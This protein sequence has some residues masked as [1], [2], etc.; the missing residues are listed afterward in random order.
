MLKLCRLLGYIGA[1]VELSDLI[2]NSDQSLAVQA[3]SS[4]T[5]NFLNVAGIGFTAWQND[6]IKPQKPFSYHSTE[7]PMYDRN[8][9][10]LADKISTNCA[11][12]HIRATGYMPGTSNIITIPN[13]HPFQFKNTDVVLAHN[14][15]L[16][17]FDSIKLQITDMCDDQFSLQVQ[18]NTDSEWIYALLMSNLNK[19]RAK[20]S[21]QKLADATLNTLSDIRKLRQSAGINTHSAA[22]LI[23][24]NG[25]S[26]IA[27]CFTYDFGCY[28]GLIN[29]AVLS[30]EMHSLWFS[31]GEK[32]GCF[33]GHWTMQK[34]KNKPNS[35]LVIASEPLSNDTSTWV[36]LQKYTMLVADY[37]DGRLQISTREIDI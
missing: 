1:P 3:Y 2:F 10:R 8:L 11:V 22:N 4:N 5:Q 32:F 26:L 25:K 37:S 30:P 31:L 13:C 19:N 20:L 29:Q 23:I 27:T 9:Q 16:A 12:G 21:A 6:S 17:A 7:L 15:G 24:S 28:D 33:E 34:Q 35:S 18:G 14:G 36:E